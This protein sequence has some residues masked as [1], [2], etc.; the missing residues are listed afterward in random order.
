MAAAIP[1]IAV[2]ASVAS[3]AYSAYSSYRAGREEK[4]ESRRAA[5]QARLRAAQ[6]AKAK[7]KEHRRIIA[8]QKA[9]YLG[10]GL[11]ME[12]S[13]L[14]VE[15]ESLKE[16]EEELAR[17]RAGGEAYATEYERAGTAAQRSGYVG[18]VGAGVR[19]GESLL[20]QGRYYDWW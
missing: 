4:K 10:S 16:S 9:R 3:T 2:V 8:R 12:G 18:A 19:G 14:L 17:I 1:V 11:T 5:E 6:R 13:P 7:E 15:M 20:R